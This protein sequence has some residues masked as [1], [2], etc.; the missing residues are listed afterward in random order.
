MKLEKFKKVKEAK[1][2]GTKSKYVI[3]TE[4]VSYH[5]CFEFTVYDLIKDQTVC[6]TFEQEDAELICTALITVNNN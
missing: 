4:S 2:S 5:C 1:E 6:E 3:I